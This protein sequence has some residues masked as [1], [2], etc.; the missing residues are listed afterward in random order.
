MRTGRTHTMAVAAFIAVFFCLFLTFPAEAAKEKK[1][2]KGK[3]PVPAEEAA[4]QKPPLPSGWMEVAFI[5]VG[6]GDATIVR[7]PDGRTCLI[8]TGYAK[9]ADTLVGNLEKRGIRTLDLVVLTHRHKDH[10]GGYPAIADAFPI[11]RVVEPY[12]PRDPAR[13]LRVKP[14]NVLIE[15]KGYKLTA[16]GPSQANPD[17]ND[18]SLVLK[19][20]FG[21]ISFLFAADILATG[22]E[23]LL[24][25]GFDLRAD[26]LKVPHHGT[27]KGGSAT[28]FFMAVRPKYAI[29][30]CDA[31]KG[32][33][34]DDGVAETLQNN[35]ATVLRTDEAG[36]VVFRTNGSDLQPSF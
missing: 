28:P 27:Y 15:G 33:V 21:T 31:G 3:K 5:N 25:R 34:P 16:L 29:I 30:T 11:A 13:T 26:V 7:L 12:D 6:K 14:G 10:A 17:E 19:L 9:T 1:G 4:T 36:N 23:E 32:D 18:G 24:S 20:E 22:Q 35:G 8:D 2:K